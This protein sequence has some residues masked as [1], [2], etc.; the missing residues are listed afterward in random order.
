[1]NAVITPTRAPSHQPIA[2]PTVAPSI[3]SVLDKD[4]TVEWKGVR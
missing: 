2:L 3:A 4:V 1:M